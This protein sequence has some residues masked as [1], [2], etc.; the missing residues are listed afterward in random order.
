MCTLVVRV[1]AY[2]PHANF[3]S[4]ALET[5]NPKAQNPKLRLEDLGFLGL[6]ESRFKASVRSQKFGILDDRAKNTRKLWPYL[7]KPLNFRPSL[8]EPHQK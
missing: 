1:C 7:R 4:E 3:G 8:Q 6:G 2:I 5:T